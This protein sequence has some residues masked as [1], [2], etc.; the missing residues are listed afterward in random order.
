MLRSRFFWK[1]Y[2]SYS[3][4]ILLSSLIVGT[5]ISRRMERGALEEVRQSLAVRASFL[6]ERASR[7]LAE[8]PDSSFQEHI[9]VLG[10][11]IGARLTVINAKGVVVADS[12]QNPST[13]DNRAARPEIAAA[14]AQA[15]GT[16]VR[17]SNTLGARIMYVALAV[18]NEGRLVGYVRTAR[19]LSGV[20]ERLASIREALAWGG[21]LSAAA[22]LL[23]GLFLTRHF[24]KPLASMTSAAESMSRGNYDSRLSA[25]RKDEIGDLARA[26]NR[27]AESSR[28]RTGTIS[29]DRKKLSAILSG[30]AEGVVAVSR[31][32]RVVHLNEAAGKLLGT[33][34]DECLDKPVWQVTRVR[35]V[36]EILGAALQEDAETQRNLRIV[37][38]ARDRFIKMHA[39]PLHDGQGNLAGAVAVLHDLTEVH[40][41]DMVRRE[42]VANASHELKTPITAIR[43]L[44]ETLI[45]DAEL[46]GALRKRFLVK[47]RDQAMR[48]SSIVID[49]LALSRLETGSEPEAAPCDLRDVVLTSVRNFV[50]IG[51][52]QGISV[53]AEVPN[54]LIEVAA[55]EEAICQAVSNLLD[56]ALKYTPRGGRVVARLSR[57]GKEGVIEV[58]DTGIGIEPKDRER[59]FERFYRVDKARSKELGGTGLGLS[60]VKHIALTH[61]GRV[62]V[63]S[64][65][66]AGSTFKVFLPLEPIPT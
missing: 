48:L 66:G 22:A 42:F 26:L 56:N 63:N 34:A 35:E 28:E 59:I 37:S 52:E 19:P 8:S 12:D 1:L 41:L 65:P 44:V 58:Q 32:E 36:S 38:Q 49:L 9:R 21:G 7:Y 54:T 10:A 30:M 15:Q 50:S 5:V 60:I 46:P 53:K 18:R 40:R 57:E 29:A 2:A 4:L 47:I 27:M 11:R 16:S 64:V 43:G 3:A 6:Q 55:D 17:F 33:S 14:G 45:D 62:A 23:P 25:A 31:D 39:S 20:D 24:V 51:E 61:K 13:M